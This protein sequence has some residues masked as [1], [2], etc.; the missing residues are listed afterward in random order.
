MGIG[1]TKGKPTH[2][3]T[4]SVSIIICGTKDTPIPA[5]TIRAMVPS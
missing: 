2:P 4:S 1:G 3:A 5:A